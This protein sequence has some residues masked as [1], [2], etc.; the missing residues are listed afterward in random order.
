MCCTASIARYGICKFLSTE[1]S[2]SAETSKYVDRGQLQ[3]LQA[4]ILAAML[5]QHMV[6]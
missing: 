5:L 4:M 2:C 6:A 1:R 3:M